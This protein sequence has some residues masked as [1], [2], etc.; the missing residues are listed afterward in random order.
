MV[1]P[2]IR[3]LSLDCS[4]FPLSLSLPYPLSPH[5]SGSTPAP[6]H[7]PLLSHW[8]PADGSHCSCF[9][10]QLLRLALEKANL[11]ISLH[12]WTSHGPCHLHCPFPF[13]LQH[14]SI[15]S[16]PLRLSEASRTHHDEL[17]IYVDALTCWRTQN[18]FQ[19]LHWILSGLSLISQSPEGWYTTTVIC[20]NCSIF[21]TIKK[22][23]LV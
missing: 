19:S 8:L 1:S 15:V 14:H 21:L 5:P 7:S 20:I 11:I 4:G 17:L 13:Y 9:S 3:C 6:W 16:L 10:P 12:L 23:I 2:S 22:D 18:E